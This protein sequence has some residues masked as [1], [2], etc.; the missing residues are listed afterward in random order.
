VS[1]LRQFLNVGRLFAH[2]L[3][4]LAAQDLLVK[5]EAVP[6][7]KNGGRVSRRAQSNFLREKRFV[8]NEKS[9]HFLEGSQV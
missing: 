7:L 4:G 3:R 1:S 2:N 8:K 9:R 6:D 5:E